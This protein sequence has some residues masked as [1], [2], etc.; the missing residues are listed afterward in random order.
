MCSWITDVINIYKRQGWAG[1]MA[2]WLKELIWR[3]DVPSASSLHLQRKRRHPASQSW[4]LISIRSLWHTH[5][6]THKHTCIH[7]HIHT[8][9]GGGKRRQGK[10]QRQTQRKTHTHIYISLCWEGQTPSSAL[11]LDIFLARYP[12]SSL[13]SLASRKTLAHE[14]NSVTFYAAILLQ[15]W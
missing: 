15:E 12:V 8:Q 1:K 9:R 7:I 6:F 13:T 10:N 14:Q 4:L 2:Q 5:A 3:A 11:C